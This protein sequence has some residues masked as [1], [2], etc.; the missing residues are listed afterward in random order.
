MKMRKELNNKGFSLVELLIATVILAIIV[1][2]L[3]HSFVTSANTTVKSRQMGNV[4]L[5]SQFLCRLLPIAVGITDNCNFILYRFYH[6]ASPL[7]VVL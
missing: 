5:L 2:P 4:T 7:C 6:L 3:L 1:A